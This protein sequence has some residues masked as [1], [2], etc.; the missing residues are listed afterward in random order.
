[1]SANSYGCQRPGSSGIFRNPGLLLWGV[2]AGI[3]RSRKSAATRNEAAQTDQKRLV[4]SSAL[5]QSV[6]LFERRRWIRAETQAV[7]QMH[8]QSELVADETQAFSTQ[9]ACQSV[10]E[11]CINAPIERN[12]GRVTVFRD[13]VV[14]LPPDSSEIRTIDVKK[15]D[16]LPRIREP[17]NVANPQ[18]V[19]V[20]RMTALLQDTATDFAPVRSPHR[21]VY[22]VA[23]LG[24]CNGPLHVPQQRTYLP[25]RDLQEYEPLV[26]HWA[27]GSGSVAG[28]PGCSH[29]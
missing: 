23:R 26:S 24:P 17:S 18:R 20:Q 5:V 22:R 25:V 7:T 11:R 19:A 15:D 6:R 10:R 21:K 28:R 13:R 4:D 3:A 16:F 1:M 29:A 8:R 27:T 14:G 12:M 2:T 9:E